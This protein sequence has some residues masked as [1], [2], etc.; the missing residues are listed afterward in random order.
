MQPYG[1]VAHRGRWYLCG[2]DS[3]SGEVRTFRL[4]RV[5]RVQLGEGTFEAPEQLDVRSLVLESLAA[6]PWRHRVTVRVHGT[7][8]DVRARLPPGLATVDPAEEPGWARVRMRVE[9]LD[10]V[11]GVVVSLAA[12]LDTDVFVEEPPE[13]HERVQNLARRL[14]DPPP[15]VDDD[16]APV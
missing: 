9:N 6:T 4:D 12:D 10:W 8:D 2:A 5:D 15:A 16:Q 7:V 1:L 11:P 14:S 13:L 3:R